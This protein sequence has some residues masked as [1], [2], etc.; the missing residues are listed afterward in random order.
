[1]TRGF[2]EE[3]TAGESGRSSQ[4]KWS[5]SSRW[6]KRSKQRYGTR[7]WDGSTW[8]GQW[9]MGCR[10]WDR[11]PGRGVNRNA[12]DAGWHNRTTQGTLHGFFTEPQPPSQTNQRADSTVPWGDQPEGP[13]ELPPLLFPEDMERGRSNSALQEPAMK[14]SQVTSSITYA[15]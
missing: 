15:S 12:Q 14:T 9:M 6:R 3:R 7:E 4:W 8:K 1:M 11:G 2:G 5:R 13:D 10:L